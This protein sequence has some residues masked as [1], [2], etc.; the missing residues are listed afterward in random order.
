MIP[1]DLS[2][3]CNGRI[4]DP[5]LSE[6]GSICVELD[7]GSIFSD[8]CTSLVERDPPGFGYKIFTS[9]QHDER[10]ANDIQFSA[11]SSGVSSDLSC[12]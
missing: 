8:P 4:Y 1:M 11:C 2:T 6:P 10:G 5:I 7:P 3:K 9:A 12:R